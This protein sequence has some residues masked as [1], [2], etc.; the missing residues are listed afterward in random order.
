MEYIKCY[1]DHNYSYAKEE[2]VLLYYEVDTEEE[3]YAVRCIDIYAD[4]RIETIQDEE[5][6]F[7]TEGPVPTVTEINE[8]YSETEW[9]DRFR[10]CLITKAEFERVWIS[11]IYEEKEGM[12]AF[13]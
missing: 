5:F 12:N 8:E 10:A 11:S 1:W 4:G 6:G 2:P 3:R 9:G 13:Q 7:V